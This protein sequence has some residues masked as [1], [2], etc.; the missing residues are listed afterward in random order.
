MLPLR[1]LGNRNIAGAA[2]VSFCGFAVM[3]IA[4][5][6]I[7][8]LYQSVFHK[9]A[10]TAGVQL[11]PLIMVQIVFL[12]GSGR[13][14]AIIGRPWPFIFAGPVLITIAS[15][16]L[17]MVKSTSTN[18]MIMGFQ[19][20]LGAGIGL[21]LQNTI[22]VGQ[23]EYQNEPWMISRATGAGTFFGFTGRIVGISLAG[24]VFQNTIRQNLDKYAPD[25]PKDLQTAIASSADAVWTVVPEALRPQVLD[26]YARTIANVFII[27][28]PFGIIAVAGS[29]VIENKRYDLKTPVKTDGSKDVNVKEEQ[30]V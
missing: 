3:M 23:W 6:Y 29:F 22:L 8:V 28:V 4:I 2:I 13:I 14:I 19:A 9:S 27:G 17:Y 16:L 21:F 18:S 1:M 5:Y 25:L 7:S 20:I 10:V 24:S 26:A 11:L 12:I 30:K 15:G